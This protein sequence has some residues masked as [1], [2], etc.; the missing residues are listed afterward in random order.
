ML[1]AGHPPLPLHPSFFFLSCLVWFFPPSLPIL[2]C[3]PLSPKD[4]GRVSPVDGSLPCCNRDFFFSSLL[5]FFK[6]AVAG[7][8]VRQALGCTVAVPAPKYLSLDASGVFSS[9]SPPSI[10]S[11]C[12]AGPH[13]PSGSVISNLLEALLFRSWGEEGQRVPCSAAPG[14]AG[15]PQG[16]QDSAGSQRPLRSRGPGGGVVQQAGM[17]QGSEIGLIS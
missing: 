10:V 7:S 1:A 15:H 3:V 2:T 13:L 11:A 8:Q 9:C 6:G 12:Q 16:L 5:L 14:I 4:K 17:G